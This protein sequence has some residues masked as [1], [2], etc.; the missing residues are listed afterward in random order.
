MSTLLKR[1]MHAAQLSGETFPGIPLVEIAGDSRVLVENHKGVIYYGPKEVRVNVSYG[2]L[3]V[4]GQNLNMARL[5]KDQLVITG[6][7]DA[8]S[9]YRWRG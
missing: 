5:A 6:E 1:M 4:C 9:L 7:I 2:F 8:V 3:C